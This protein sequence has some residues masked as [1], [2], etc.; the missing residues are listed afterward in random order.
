MV[1]GRIPSACDSFSWQKRT[2]EK[3]RKRVKSATP[4]VDMTPPQS[5]PH[6]LYDAK[7]LQLQQER[8]AQIIRDNF[9]LLRNLQNIMHGK[10]KKKNYRLDEKRSECIRIF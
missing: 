10:N 3:H 9:I 1:T 6:V 5:R 2:Y 8:Q 7:R 4:T